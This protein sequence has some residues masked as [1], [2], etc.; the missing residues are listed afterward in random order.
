M[1]R[2]LAI[3]GLTFREGLRMRI[4][5]VFLAVL[6]LV[7][8]RLP[9]ALHGDET[10]AGR[11]QTFLSY[12]LAALGVL[13]SLVTVFLSCATLTVDI[14]DHSIQL[15]VTKPVSRFE[16][17]AGKWL[18]VNL[19]NVLIVVLSGLAIYGF[20]VFIK[21]RPEQFERDRLKVT[22]VVWT[23]RAAA[24][25]T[26][27]DF[28]KM[29]QQHVEQMAAQ[30]RTFPLGKQAAIRD[31]AK[32][33]KE[34]WKQVPPRGE[35]VY[36]FENLAPPD[37]ADAVYQVRFKARAVPVG[38]NEA[39]D[40]GWVIIDPKTNAPLAARQTAERSAQR[41]Q[42]LVRSSVVKDGRALIGVINPPMNRRRAIYFEGDDGL[43]ILYK[44]GGFEFNFV[45]N[46][47]LILFRL[48]FL[49][50]LGVFFGT[51]VSFPV[52]CFCVLTLFVFC[53]GVPWWLE[54]IGA[55]MEHI[56][57]KVDPY[58]R[59]GPFVRGLLVPVLRTL[60]PNFAAYDGVDQLI[61]GYAI[62]AKLMLRSAA[63]T[64][65]YGLVLLALPGW[66]IF[67]SREIAEVIV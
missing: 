65:I 59:F 39:L 4:V 44:V 14:R 32:E 5:L 2:I 12:S 50:A 8:F 18:G 34:E 61:D 33:L 54:A 45:K 22:D 48:A 1:R 3:A 26:A 24:R 23:A 62:P 52:A 43:E 66:L 27:P 42:F 9:F 16:V 49:S 30:G 28:A 38:V 64:L 15:V 56:D 67:R 13:M 20:A 7:V 36:E 10:L 21:T 35:R 11:L 37:R 19:L 60:L 51:F 46:L 40:I 57:P 58:G 41:H 55:N 63:H 6:L 29:A 25:P 17:L 47:V 53:L 31:M